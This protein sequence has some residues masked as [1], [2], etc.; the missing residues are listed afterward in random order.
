MQSNNQASDASELL[1]GS[2]NKMAFLVKLY[3]VEK[4]LWGSTAFRHMDTKYAS[5]VSISHSEYVCGG[6]LVLG[7]SLL[8]QRKRVL[9]EVFSS[10]VCEF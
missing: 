2:K 1:P 3:P 5:K 6:F 10:D 4:C 9:K 8:L 7:S